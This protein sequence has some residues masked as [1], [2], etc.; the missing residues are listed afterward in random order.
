MMKV[1][2]CVLL[3]MQVL[4]FCVSAPSTAEKFLAQQGPSCE[5]AEDD[6]TPE[7]DKFCKE[8]ERQNKIDKVCITKFG[9]AWKVPSTSFGKATVINYDNFSISAMPD[10]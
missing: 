10:F 4:E 3:F 7:L 9:H 6:F 1:L 5:I 2:L 8:E